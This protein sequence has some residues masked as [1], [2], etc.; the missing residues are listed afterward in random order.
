MIYEKSG[1]RSEARQ[2]YEVALALAPDFGEA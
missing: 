2:Q 1:R